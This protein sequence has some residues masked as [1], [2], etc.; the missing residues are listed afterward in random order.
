ML[1]YVPCIP[2]LM[3]AF[4]MNDAEPSNAFS[5]SIE[6]MIDFYPSFY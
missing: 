4:F 1:R 2:T 5:E 6:M 3:I